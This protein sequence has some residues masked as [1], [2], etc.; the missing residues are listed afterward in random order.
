[1][2]EAQ[3]SGEAPDQAG[4]VGGRIASWYLART[5][6]ERLHLSLFLLA[7]VLYS[8]HYL[9]FCWPQ[10]FFIEDSAITFS[11]ARN[12]MQG[13]GLVPFH[14][15]ERVE[16]YSN[17]LWM[18][19]IAIAW[20]VGVEVWFSAKIYGYLFGLITMGLSYG[21]ARRM[22]PGPLNAAPLLPPFLLAASTQFVLW[23]ASGLEN[24]LFN[25]MLAGGIYLTLRESE[26][27]R[28]FPWSVLCFLGLAL[29]RPD[30]V[31]YASIGLLT[32]TLVTI[33]RG[34]LG[35]LV[36]PEGRWR[37][38]PAL[39]LWLALFTVPFALYHAWRYEYFAWIW[40]NTYYAK[41]KT[42]RPFNWGGNGWP[43]LREYMTLYGI[44]FAAP[45]TLLGL[46]GESR[47][48][49]LVGVGMLVGLS[50]L[51]LWSFDGALPGWMNVE[52]VRWLKIHWNE[53]RVW[54]ILGMGVALG[55]MSLGQPGWEARATLWACYCTGLF[56][57]I[58]SGGDW[59]KGYRWFSLT[60]VPQFILI[61][62]GMYQFAELIPGAWKRIHGRLSVQNLYAGLL[63]VALAIPNI[64]QSYKFM[65]DAETAVR[66]VHQRVRYMTG[67]QQKLDL[68]DVVLLDVDMG[69]HMWY[70]DWYILD[71]AGLIEVPVA[72]HDWQRAFAEDYIL[73]EY[74]PH[75]AHVHGAWA[76][77]TGLTNIVGFKE[78]YLEI[79]GFPAGG[80]SL[81]VGNHIR[82]DLVVRP[83]YE[84][85]PDR[86]VRFLDADRPAAAPAP[87]PA[88]TPDTLDAPAPA[89]DAVDAPAPAD[90]SVLAAGEVRLEG[91]DMPAPAV[92]PGGKLF[93]QSVWRSAGRA[94][95]LYAVF[96]NAKGDVHATEVAPAWD[97][98]AP[99]KWGPKE[100]VLGNWAIPVPERL[101]QG[102]W[103]LGF[104]V[105][106]RKTGAVIPASGGP[107]DARY[108]KGEIRLG[109]FG[110]VSV[111]AAHVRAKDVLDGAV[112]AAAAGDCEAAALGWKNARRHI[113]RD[114]A[115]HEAKDPIWRGAMIAC[116]IRRSAAN[117]DIEAQAAPLI[118][119]WR[120]DHRD[121]ALLAVAGPLGE[122][123]EALG[124]ERAAVKD[125]EGA[126][127]AFSAAVKVDARRS[128]A[129]RKAEE[130]RDHR[131][132]IKLKSFTWEEP[133]FG[134]VQIAPVKPSVKTGAKPARPAPPP[135]PTVTPDE[136]P[137]NPGGD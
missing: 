3:R 73:T 97:W 133:F 89:P 113:A 36:A 103:S 101:E 32:R 86:Q 29:T 130:C 63:V 71:I 72:R 52:P 120:I 30:G 100:Y 83:V 10:P 132:K 126:F 28:I 67:V 116:L 123:L 58:F 25:L 5:Q 85:P 12:L 111:D 77:S 22:F 20:K 13:E 70:T 65:L 127:R 118:Q 87:A 66:D 35:R 90:P 95:R 2:S 60:S 24:S 82:K 47:W 115:W 43:A 124:D 96:S 135:T 74:R 99:E 45:A 128:W 19:L 40:P 57:Q 44:I 49:R 91:W 104:V 80:T 137:E 102:E 59:M 79:P 46:V 38:V 125:W 69:A 27:N 94:F 41:E 108:M 129:R 1:M 51:V 134:E 31:A 56:F 48:R 50:G 92:A 110:I 14:G 112:A 114:T 15:S 26:E 106:D 62:V 18:L 4:S 75:F 55:L 61:G 117:D 119:A 68:D 64:P 109:T 53:L 33:W 98:Y 131:L 6:Q 37:H 107:A 17:P 7:V 23:N 105:V 88:P 84:G 16:G 9:V 122:R 81:H 42:F 34:G 78:D 8:L 54:Y 39:L 76:R 121:P 21:I 11:Y 93:V 136:A